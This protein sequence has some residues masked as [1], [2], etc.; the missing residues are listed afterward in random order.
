M[1]LLPVSSNLDE[2]VASDFHFLFIKNLE[3][4]SDSLT[5]IESLRKQFIK[6]LV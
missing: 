3:F 2:T 1:K 6:N 4:V 5:K